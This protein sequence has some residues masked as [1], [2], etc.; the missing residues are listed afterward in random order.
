MLVRMYPLREGGQPLD[1]TKV[2]ARGPT[3]AWMTVAREP[4]GRPG[5]WQRVATLHVDRAGEGLLAVLHD[6]ELRSWDGRGL[7]FSGVEEI[8]RHRRSEHFRQSWLI[9]PPGDPQRCQV[10]KLR[11]RGVRRK[12]SEVATSIPAAGLLSVMKGAAGGLRPW[13]PLAMLRETSNAIDCIATLHDVQLISMDRRGVVLTGG[14]EIVRARKAEVVRQSW[15]V[16]MDGPA[17]VAFPP[18]STH[19]VEDPEEF[20]YA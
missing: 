5:H 2:R 20:I 15:F 10:Y 3:E 19:P 9:V 16:V 6:A 18:Y 1:G 4:G 12:L 11:E 7:L 14:E 17:G 8:H 13:H